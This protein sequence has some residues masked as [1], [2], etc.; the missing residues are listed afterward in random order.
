MLPCGVLQDT[1]LAGAGEVDG[2]RS[3]VEP[4]P[5]EPRPAVVD[6]TVATIGAVLGVTAG[7]AAVVLGA[8]AA[9]TLAGADVGAVPLLSATNSDVALFTERPAVVGSL[10]NA[11]SA[12]PCGY[13]VCV[14]MCCAAPTVRLQASSKQ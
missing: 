2:A 3:K 9:E 13:G 12:V 7:A 5:L 10:F 4:R 8:G 11:G 6:G 1:P 14:V